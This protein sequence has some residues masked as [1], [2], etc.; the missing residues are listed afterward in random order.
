MTTVFDASAIIAFLSMEQG[1]LIVRQTLRDNPGSCYVHAVNLC[2]VYYHVA[3][4]R[5]VPAAE[6]TMRFLERAGSIVREDMDAA[7]WQDA[8]RLKATYVRVSLADCYCLALARRLG[9]EA[10]TADHHEFDALMPHGL[11]PIRFIR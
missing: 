5:G 3:R 4:V 11:C 10:L 1:A 8:G 2:E 7:F 9:G 6:R